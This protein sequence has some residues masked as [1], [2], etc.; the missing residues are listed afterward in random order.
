MSSNKLHGTE[1]TP[2]RTVGLSVPATILDEALAEWSDAD[3][4]KN[5]KIE[6]LEADLAEMRYIA[7]QIAGWACLHEHHG[8]R[9]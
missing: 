7:S 2:D 6:R 5:R 8:T 3:L 1:A 9:H 4:A